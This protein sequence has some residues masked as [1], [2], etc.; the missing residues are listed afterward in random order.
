MNAE[1]IEKL[2]VD[3]ILSAC[4]ELGGAPSDASLTGDL[5][6]DSLTL[7]SLF[8][9]VKARFGHL[10]LAPWFISASTAGTD[11]VGSLAAFIAA[12][13]SIAAAG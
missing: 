4:P 1:H 5:G 7:A 8:A 13:T 10:E 2:L 12:R 9:A 11:T 3:E 6:L